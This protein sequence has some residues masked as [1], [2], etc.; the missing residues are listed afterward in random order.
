MVS[1]LIAKEALQNFEILLR[2]AQFAWL[3][4]V[5]AFDQVLDHLSR[6]AH[7]FVDV[8]SNR[9]PISELDPS[10]FVKSLLLRFKRNSV[11]CFQ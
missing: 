4:S 1:L 11:S 8:S 5:C 6:F 7:V 9:L 3:R 2:K 10:S